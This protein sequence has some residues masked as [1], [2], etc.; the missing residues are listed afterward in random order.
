MVAIR[1]RWYL[2]TVRA[3]FVRCPLVVKF[4]VGYPPTMV[5]MSESQPLI[6]VMLLV[7]VMMCT[8]ISVGIQNLRHTFGMEI[9]IMWFIMVIDISMMRWTPLAVTT[10]ERRYCHLVMTGPL[11]SKYMFLSA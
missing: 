9:D 3:L 2:L 11:H 6:R 1:I 5:I 4:I 7:W 10:G 8:L